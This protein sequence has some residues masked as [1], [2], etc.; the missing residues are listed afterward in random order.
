MHSLCLVVALS[1][2]GQQPVVFP[3]PQYQPAPF[4][5]PQYQLVS[6]PQPRYQPASYARPAMYATPVNTAPSRPVMA[7]SFGQP[8]GMMSGPLLAIHNQQRA[9]VGARPLS[10]NPTLS[11]VAQA[12]AN[13]IASFGRLNHQGADG[14]WPWDRARRAGYP[15]GDSNTVNE[16][17]GHNMA[18][19]S[20]AVRAWMLSNGH[21][22]NLLNPAWSE[23]GFGYAVGQNGPYWVALF[24]RG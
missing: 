2:A 12:H 15:G 10:I 3:Q 24:G 17:I 14:S 16:N 9:M 7:G 13:E 19:P 23:V 21:R 5:Q 4:P 6:S 22:V 20:G 8:G 1:L 18:D 11:G